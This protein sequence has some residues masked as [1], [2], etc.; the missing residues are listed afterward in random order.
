[1]MEDAEDFNEMEIASKVWEKSV[2]SAKKVKKKTIQ[3]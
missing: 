2:E 1:M 3:N